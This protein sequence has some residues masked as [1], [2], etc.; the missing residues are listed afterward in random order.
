MPFGEDLVGVAT[1]RG[2]HHVEPELSTINRPTG[3]S[4]TPYD[5]HPCSP[6]CGQQRSPPRRNYALLDR[7]LLHGVTR[8]PSHYCGP[9][10]E[11]VPR[12]A[13]R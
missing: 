1:F 11:P 2:A 6:P 7:A 5:C 4:A 13:T 12:S 9:R 8:R 3:I 10:G